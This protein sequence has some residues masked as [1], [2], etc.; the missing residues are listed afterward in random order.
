MVIKP[1]QTHPD[2]EDIS[3]P[4]NTL[5][6]NTAVDTY[7]GKIHIEWDSDAFVTPIG[8]LPYFIQ[9]LKLGGRFDSWVNDSPLF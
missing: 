5:P 1:K 3:S 8:Q 4:R 2:G 7:D 6:S 9:F